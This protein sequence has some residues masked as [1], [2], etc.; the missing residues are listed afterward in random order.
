MMVYT[1]Q[2]FKSGRINSNFTRILVLTMLTNFGIRCFTVFLNF[3]WSEHHTRFMRCIVISVKLLGSV[4]QE[5]QDRD[6]AFMYDGRHSVND[7]GNKIIFGHGT[8]LHVETGEQNTVIVMYLF[9]LVSGWLQDSYVGFGL[10][11]G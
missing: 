4:F 9:N 8:Q 6:S 10:A 3:G 2:W 5:K 1:V 11:M 7:A